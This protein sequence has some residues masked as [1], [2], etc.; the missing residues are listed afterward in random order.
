MQ[1]MMGPVKA[2]DKVVVGGVEKM[3]PGMKVDP[4]PYQP[5]DHISRWRLVPVRKQAPAPRR[6]RHRV[7]RR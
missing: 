4:Q 2:G 6:A 3:R 5:P 7:P 1:V